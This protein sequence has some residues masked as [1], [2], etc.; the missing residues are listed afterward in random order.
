MNAPPV[1]AQAQLNALVN[2]TGDDPSQTSVILP[3]QDPYVTF[4]DAAADNVQSNISQ[5]DPQYLQSQVAQANDQQSQPT[6]RCT[7]RS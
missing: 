2:D 4:D 3:N 5:P 6:I 1:D 7:F